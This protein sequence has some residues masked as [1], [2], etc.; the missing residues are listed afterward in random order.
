MENLADNS[1][2]G[3]ELWVATV[4]A[5]PYD[6]APNTILLI[7]K[8]EQSEGGAGRPK[9]L[10]I[11]SGRVNLDGADKRLDITHAEQCGVRGCGGVLT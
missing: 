2:D 8:G 6:F 7:G 10:L 5:E 11:S 1:E 4:V 3:E 9:G